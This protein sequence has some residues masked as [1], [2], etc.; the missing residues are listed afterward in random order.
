MQDAGVIVEKIDEAAVA[1]VFFEMRLLLWDEEIEECVALSCLFS[2]CGVGLDYLSSESG[3]LE[4]VEESVVKC[5]GPGP[6]KL[7]WNL[8]A[9]V[10]RVKDLFDETEVILGD[11][12]A[13]VASLVGNGGVADVEGEMKG[14]LVGDIASERALVYEW[15][16]IRVGAVVGYCGGTLVVFN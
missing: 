16:E 10:E 7:N 1:G 14:K 11:D 6:G 3:Y 2:N 15:C 5:I 13:G 4:M 12:S 9:E 8:T